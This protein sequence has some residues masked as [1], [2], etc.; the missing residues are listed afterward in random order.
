MPISQENDF[1]AIQINQ[2]YSIY[3]YR[4]LADCR[5]IYEDN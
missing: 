4:G 1:S 3:I 5:L 2:F